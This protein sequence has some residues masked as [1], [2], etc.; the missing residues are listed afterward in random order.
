MFGGGKGKQKR[1]VCTAVCCQWSQ[2]VFVVDGLLADK[3][4]GQAERV[5]AGGFKSSSK[6]SMD[7]C[8]FPCATE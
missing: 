1:R 6:H 7:L 4:N 3:N 5:E 8:L 2:S